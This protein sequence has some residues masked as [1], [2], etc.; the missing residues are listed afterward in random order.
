M[1]GPSVQDTSTGEGR[2]DGDPDDV[3]T[4]VQRHFTY[5]PQ[6]ESLRKAN[7]KVEVV[8]GFGDGGISIIHDNEPS[9]MKVPAQ[10]TTTVQVETTEDHP[11]AANEPSKMKLP[12][13]TTTAVQEETTEDHPDAAVHVYEGVKVVWA[14]G[15]G[16]AIIS[17][18]LGIAE[19]VTGKVVKV[20]GTDLEEIDGNIKPQLAKLDGKLNP[21][22]EAV[23]SIIL[24]A[25]GKAESIIK[26]II[27]TFLS[28][29]GLI[30]NEAE[31]PE[32]TK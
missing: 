27:V 2:Y 25:A 32:V 8:E 3:A 14:W 30:K 15:K 24:G 7:E 23:V 13:Q 19:A 16:V 12:A 17:P 10:I 26:P 9:K 1:S 22:L 5:V 31:N 21:A 18:F 11:D 29:L 20:V 4:D 28:P 6:K